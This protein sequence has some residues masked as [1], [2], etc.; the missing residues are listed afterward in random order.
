MSEPRKITSP[1]VIDRIGT[2]HENALISKTTI[3][4]TPTV[5]IAQSNFG[6]RD[7]DK[8]CSLHLCDC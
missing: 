4:T 6:G 7:V 2:K 1:Q 3:D 5:A 8:V